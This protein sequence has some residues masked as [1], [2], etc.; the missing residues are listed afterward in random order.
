MTTSAGNSG[1]GG[2]SGTHLWVEDEPRKFAM[3]IVSLLNG[4]DW[5]KL[6]NEGKKLVSERFT[7]ETNVAEFEQYLESL[8][9]SNK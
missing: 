7:W 8:V 3:R 6:S 5:G 4:H 1:I 2:E 9:T